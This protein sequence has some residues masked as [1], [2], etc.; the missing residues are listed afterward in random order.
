MIETKN[1]IESLLIQYFYN[2]EMYERKVEEISEIQYKLTGVHAVNYDG[3]KGVGVDRDKKLVRYSEKIRPIETQK[4]NYQ[5]QME[6][7]YQSLHLII[8]DSIELNILENIYR[9][10]LTYEDI[11]EKIGYNDKSYIARKKEKIIKRLTS[12]YERN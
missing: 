11:A 8:L 10:K 9:Y 1:Y 6:S 3:I 12:A 4:R 5:L 7:L 2:K